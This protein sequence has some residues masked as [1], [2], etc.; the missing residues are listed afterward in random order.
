MTEINI[1]YLFLLANKANIKL[2]VNI[3]KGIKK[4]L[5]GYKNL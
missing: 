3:K 5:I 2:K 4:N 1:L